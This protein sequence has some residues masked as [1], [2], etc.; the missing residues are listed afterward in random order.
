LK[1]ADPE[2]SVRAHCECPRR[3]FIEYVKILSVEAAQVDAID[4]HPKKAILRLDHLTYYRAG[5]PLVG[6]ELCAYKAAGWLVWI[7]CARGYN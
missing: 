6:S 3:R 2:I 1:S 7:K 5:K 4:D